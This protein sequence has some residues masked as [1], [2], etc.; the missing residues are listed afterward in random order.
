MLP[1]CRDWKYGSYLLKWTD[2]RE[3]VVGQTATL[4]LNGAKWDEVREYGTSRRTLK[5]SI[6]ISVN[7]A[8]HNTKPSHQENYAVQN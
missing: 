1:P 3:G 4:T 8:K 6:I 2:E 5:E 7:K